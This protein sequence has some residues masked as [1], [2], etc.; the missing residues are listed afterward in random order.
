MPRNPRVSAVKSEYGFFAPTGTMIDSDQAEIIFDPQPK[1]AQIWACP[2]FEVLGGG[3]KGGGKTLLGICWMLKGN[4][5]EPPDA[6]PANISYI[7]HPHYRGLVLRKNYDDLRDWVARAGEIYKHYGGVWYPSEKAFVFKSGATIMLGHL[8]D[9]DA[10]EKYQGIEIQRLNIEE[11]NQIREKQL[12]LQV[13]N[14]CRSNFPELRP[15]VYLSANPVGKGA[16]WLKEHF[17][18]GQIPDSTEIVE[19]FHHPY[20]KRDIHLTRIFI[21]MGLK[22]NPK[23]MERDPQYLASLMTLPDPL[24]RAYL[25]GDWNALANAQFFSDF[26]ADGPLTEEAQ[27]FPNAKHTISKE[28]WAN[29]DKPYLYQWMA[30][31]YGYNHPSA[32]YWAKQTQAGKIIVHRELVVRFTTP[33]VIGQEIAIRTSP[34]LAKLQSSGLD[35]CITLWCPHDMFHNRT[36][37]GT[38]AEQLAAGINTVLGPDATFILSEED[39]GLKPGEGDFFKRMEFRKKAKIVIRRVPM[40]RKVD[41]WQICRDWLDFRSHLPTPPTFDK[42]YALRLLSEPDGQKKYFSYYHTITAPPAGPPSPLMAIVRE[43]CPKLIAGIQRAAFDEDGSEDMAPAD[44]DPVTGLGGD[45]EVNAWRYLALGYK[46]Q[47]VQEPFADFLKRNIEHFKAQ[48]GPIDD[49]SLLAQRADALQMEYNQ[50]TQTAHYRTQ[51]VPRRMAMRRQL[52]GAT[53]GGGPKL[54][55]PGGGSGIPSTKLSVVGGR[56]NARPRS[57][58]NLGST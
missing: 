51:V 12:Y 43:A 20:L 47:V 40:V 44:A 32:I 52:T 1:Q 3:S 6:H 25:D 46:F 10:Y 18:I 30:M 27:Q 37:T 26:R 8:K 31:D 28:E 34:D 33:Q 54:L 38:L 11:V 48:M 29:L 49:G 22:D 9:E 2:Q 45:D 7:N 56:L 16:R 13:R 21:P 50:D 55:G 35:P 53:V 5:T 23:F 39:M 24:R 4:P 19:T 17:K 58:W 41:G 36:G 14:N 57:S 15:Q 42:D